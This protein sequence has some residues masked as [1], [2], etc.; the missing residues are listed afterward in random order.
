MLN[1]KGPRILIVAPNA[2]AIFGGEAFLPLKYFQLLRRRGHPVQMIAHIRNRASLMEALEEDLTQ[3]HFVEDT[4]YHR[5]IWRVGQIFPASVRSGI[6]DTMLN[7]LNE[8]YIAR[9]VR[10]L[11]KA[12][13]VD[14]IHQPIPVSPKAPSSLY[15]FGRPVVIGPMNGGMTYP[16]GYDDLESATARRFIAV[17]RAAAIAMNWLIPG[18]RHAAAL[19]VA[20]ERTRAAL[21]L[22]NHPRIVTVVENGVDL[23]VWHAGT[24][25]SIRRPDEPFQLVFMGRLVAL[26]AVDITIEAVR[27]ARDRGIDVRLDVFGD[28]EVRPTLEAQVR[29]LDLESAVS[30]H[31][32]QPQSKCSQLLSRADA[33]ILNSVHE[34]GGAVVLEAMSLSL[35]V[36]VSDWG[37]P[38]DYVDSTCG[39][40]VSPEPRAQFAARLADSIRQ[41]ADN[42]K[43]ARAMGE[44]GRRRIESYFDWEKKIDH[45]LMIYDEVFAVANEG[46]GRS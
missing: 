33:M 19:L 7:L 9:L 5:I 38:A 21:P 23:S 41:L 31:G 34:C 13:E 43:K 42:P 27:L 25:I 26:K 4:P 46:A 17:A 10:L 3:I 20:N 24:K 28:G 15:N 30:F 37:G 8:L 44:A 32:F 16:A 45:M 2:S 12:G 18:K 39:I 11:V 36:I 35:P 22:T 6:F 14:L 29:E 1:F 40:L